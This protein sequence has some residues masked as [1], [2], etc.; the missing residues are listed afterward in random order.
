M[1][2]PHGERFYRLPSDPDPP[3]GWTKWLLVALAV[4]TFALAFLL[5]DGCKHDRP[6]VKPI[7]PISIVRTWT[8]CLETPPPAAP[9]FAPLPGDDPRC[10]APL[11]CFDRGGAVALVQYIQSLELWNRSAWARCSQVPLP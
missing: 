6:A 1:T 3:L 9:A 8:S 4:A 2:N 10:P 11:S 7:P 5:L